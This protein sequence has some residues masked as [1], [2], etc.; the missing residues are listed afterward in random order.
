[1]TGKTFDVIVVGGGLAGGT[2]ALSAARQGAGVLLIERGRR[3][4]SKNV[5]G[6]ILY[7]PVLDRL[8]PRFSQ[9]APV[10][11]HIASKTL[12]LLT[13]R[14]Q[15][16]MEVRSE[17]FNEPPGYN[18]S[19]TVRR[20]VFDPWL[21]DKAR[22]AGAE[23]VLSTSVESLLHESDDPHGPV[24]GVRC[25]RE[26]G[27]LRA[28]VVI[29][30]EGANALLSEAQGLRPLTTPDQ[31]LL[32]VKE[33]LRLDRSLIEDRFHLEG[34]EGRAYEFFGDPV[35]DGFGSGFLYTNKESLSVGVA[36]TLSHLLR[37]RR[38]PHELLDRFKAHP[39]I[40][41]LIRGAEPVEYCAHLLPAG[42]PS[43]MPALTRDG[44]LLAGDAA[45]LAN[46]SHYKELTNL[47]TASGVAA[48]EAAADAVRRGDTTKEGLK[49]YEARLA[50]GF[51]LRDVRK[52]ARLSDLLERRPELLRKYPRMLVESFVEHFTLSEK[53]KD[54]VE[55][56][57][58]RSWNKAVRPA[59]LRRDLVDAL[60]ACGFSMAPLLRSMAEPSLKA[61]WDWLRLI[62]P[63]RKG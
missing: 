41:R 4:G 33:V 34:D 32:G 45:R 49:D 63:W 6:G 8:F 17:D 48:G 60:E 31:V 20:T 14:S 59:E 52:Y 26:G 47:V 2:A 43:G 25:G 39:S 30:A 50:A 57:I 29:L 62:T 18:H 19:Y 22:E 36:A 58:L 46:M 56:T 13:E 15:L 42:A 37:L 28:K 38:E 55:K 23:V 61:G 53:P 11:R 12:G 3:P 10:E 5:I 35:F 27:E 16:S 54:E 40:R 1:M 51:V 9:E 21:L 7:S 44:L 24:A